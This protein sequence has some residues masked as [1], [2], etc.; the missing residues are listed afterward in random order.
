MAE[1]T[2]KLPEKNQS[3]YALWMN[4][5]RKN[6]KYKSLPL[7]QSTIILSKIWNE[8]NQEAKMVLYST[9]FRNF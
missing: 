5:Q 6:E 7:I 8:L 3:A 9:F 4:E 2:V 1:T